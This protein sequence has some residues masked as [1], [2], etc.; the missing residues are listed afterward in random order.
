[1]LDHYLHEPDHLESEGYSNRKAA[2]ERQSKQVVMDL[3][4]A[5]K[6]INWEPWCECSYKGLSSDAYNLKAKGLKYLDAAKR[7]KDEHWAQRKG[8]AEPSNRRKPTQWDSASY[9]DPDAATPEWNVY[10][11]NPSVF[12]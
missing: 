2:A 8:K 10:K 4:T 11:E 7:A 6:R 9:L 3:A 5:N 12:D 1:M